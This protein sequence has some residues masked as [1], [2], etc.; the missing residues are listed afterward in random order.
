MVLTGS[1]FASWG[2]DADS[3]INWRNPSAFW[4]TDDAAGGVGEAGGAVCGSRT[5]GG[6]S[7]DEV[8]ARSGADAAGFLRGGRAGE[9]FLE[10]AIRLTFFGGI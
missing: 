5:T 9:A 10:E 7:T 3:P 2:A 8:L 4:S 1:G 6:C